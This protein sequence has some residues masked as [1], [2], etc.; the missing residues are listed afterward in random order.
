M[1]ALRVRRFGVLGVFALAMLCAC[2]GGSTP[3]AGSNSAPSP[4]STAFSASAASGNLIPLPS[5]AGYGGDLEIGHGSGSALLTLSTSAP[6]GAPS[7][8]ISCCE[9]P[10]VYV[11]IF[12]Q[13][14]F[15]LDTLPGLN[16]LTVPASKTVAG[17]YRLI[18]YG[19]LSSGTLNSGR[20]GWS[21]GNAICF[22]MIGSPIDLQAGQSLYS[23][24]V[25]D[26][27]LPTPIGSAPPCPQP[28]PP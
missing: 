18:T 3:A 12:A 26:S 16:P 5:A 4:N 23:V 21:A 2:G 25:A 8:P 24:V 15:S 20:V 1:N 19:A 17:L 27:V 7:P 11:T 22:P 10:L 14:A 13:T 6:S 28:P 9:Q